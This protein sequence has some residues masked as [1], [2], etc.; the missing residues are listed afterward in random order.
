MAGWTVFVVVALWWLMKIAGEQDA[1]SWVLHPGDSLHQSWMERVRDWFRL[2]H[3]NFQRIYP[4][5]LLGP[6]V[7]WLG[8]RFALERERLRLSLLVHLAGCAGFILAARLINERATNHVARVVIIT[9]QSNID[10]QPQPGT[11]IVHIEIAKASS[12][13][14]AHEEFTRRMTGE[15]PGLPGPPDFLY[16]H[17]GGLTNAEMI[18]QPAESDKDFLFSKFPPE[19]PS[20]RPLSVLLD[21]LAYGA[22]VG[23]AHS[24]H[25]YR[26]YREREHRAILLES[27][28]AK[29]RLNALQTQLQPH[30]LFN[31]L[32]AIATLL[33]RDPRLAEVT[34]MSLSDLLRLTLNQSS[35]QEVT[36]REELQIVQS[37]LEIQQTR[38]GERL[39]F[40]QDIQPAA[41]DCFVPTLLLQPLIENAIRHGIEPAENAGL[42]RLTASRQTNTLVLTIEDDGVGFSEAALGSQKL[43]SL[44]SN[45]RQPAGAEV[46][47]PDLQATRPLGSSVSQNGTGIGLANLRARLETLYGA[48]QKLELRPRQDKGVIVRVEIPWR[49]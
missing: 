36:L 2:A 22:I 32:N 6:Y 1:T 47:N 15:L 28:L 5:V 9:S 24:I 41:L 34:L 14:M 44:P 13:V 45:S 27:S 17:R 42:V 8:A 48:A 49:T 3:F 19:L 38:F 20:L 40:E 10:T 7:A 21:L 31:S 33:R 26:R 30:F 18:N 4:W 12:D 43:A 35:K 46:A 23:M 29:A 25:F 37:Y 16:R 39:H 11:N